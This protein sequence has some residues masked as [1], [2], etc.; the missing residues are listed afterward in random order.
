M[1]DGA[2]SR[3][4]ILGFADM[5]KSDS[6]SGNKFM[7]T[8]AHGTIFTLGDISALVTNNPTC[9]A[10]FVHENSYFLALGEIFFYPLKCHLRKIRSNLLAHIYQKNGFFDGL[11]GVVKAFII[12]NT[13][14]QKN[15][16]GMIRQ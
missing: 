16:S 4:T 3:Y 15:K 8:N 9:I 7:I 2:S 12:H 5:T 1:T 10:L 13:L 6:F 14:F 11:Y